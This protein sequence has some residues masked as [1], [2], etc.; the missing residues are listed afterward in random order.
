MDERN[1]NGNDVANDNF[2]GKSA[3]LFLQWKKGF[4]HLNFAFSD[5]LTN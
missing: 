1:G 2:S 4:C 3:A 5:G